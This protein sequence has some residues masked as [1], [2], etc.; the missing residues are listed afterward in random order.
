M[1]RDRAGPST[2]NT[3]EEG[4]EKVCLALDAG[5]GSR[6]RQFDAAIVYPRWLDIRSLPE[7]F[8]ECASTAGCLTVLALKKA[9]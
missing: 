7:K 1:K 9:H 8:R 2:R 4:R 5:R 6:A 3:R